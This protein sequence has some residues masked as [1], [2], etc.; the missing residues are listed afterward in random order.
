MKNATKRKHLPGFFAAGICFG[1]ALTFKFMLIGYGVTALVLAAAGVC[2][3]IYSFLPRKIKIPFTVLLCVGAVIF[4]AAEI[5][6]VKASRGTPDTDAEYLIVL[7][8]GVNGSAPSLSLVNRLTAAKSYLESHPDCIA[9]VTGGQG[10]GENLTEAQAMADWLTAQGI[11]AERILREER[12]TSTAENLEYSFALIPDAANAK[13]AVCSS[14]YHLCR[15]E[16]MARQM[17]YTL[18]GVPG[19]T[20]YPLLR[21]NYFVR[22][23]FGMVYL[24]V[25]G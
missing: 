25:F 19:H 5:P 23:G 2:I 12:A 22:E 11:A 6:V 3:L 4:T 21:L 7:G 8:A 20:T 24:W 9:V 18:S 16:Y 17:G 1:L 13:I 15:A 14:E 10:R